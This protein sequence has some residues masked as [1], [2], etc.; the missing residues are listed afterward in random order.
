MGFIVLWGLKR[1]GFLSYGVI[2]VHQTGW[3]MEVYDGCGCSVKGLLLE[4]A[5]KRIS[6]Y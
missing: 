2:G 1:L 3:V 5:Y 4:V 6:D